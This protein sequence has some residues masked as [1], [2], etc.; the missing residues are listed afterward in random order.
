MI[1]LSV[2]AVLSLPVLYITSWYLFPDEI[3]RWVFPSD[4]CGDPR[5]R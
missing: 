5:Y 3:G 1:I 2:G 4:P